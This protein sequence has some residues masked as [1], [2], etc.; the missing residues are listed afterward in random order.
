MKTFIGGSQDI[1]ELPMRAKERI[2]EMMDNGVEI[3]V[4]DAKGAD[5]AVQKYL[6][7]NRYDDV[8]VYCSGDFPRNNI[9]RWKTN[10]IYVPDHVKGFQFHAAKDRA[11]AED[12][13]EGLML[14]DG[15][16][17]G[18]VLNVLRLAM[19]NKKAIL[20]G[21]SQSKGIEFNNLADWKNFIAGR[22]DIAEKLCGRATPEEL[23]AGF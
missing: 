5:T 19:N 12:A 17:S 6:Y 18:T 1:T 9:G 10:N 11:M 16:S 14:W 7:D 20:L 13:D 8:T 23:K 22:G 4:G 3:L 21:A 2:D 15:Q